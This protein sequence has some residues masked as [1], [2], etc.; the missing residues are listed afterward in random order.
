MRLYTHPA[1]LR[2][3]GG[4]GHP[5]SPA[6]LSA[7]LQAIEQA[8]FSGIEW[9]EAPLASRE[10]LARAHGSALIHRVLDVEVGPG[11]RRIDADTAMN[12]DSAEAALRAAGA[13]CAAIDAVLGGEIRRAFCAVRPPGHHATRDE[14]MGFC[15]FNS[16][17]VGAMHALATHA[18]QRVAIVDFDV[19]HGNGSQDI[20]WNE[21]RIMYLSSHQ[22]ALYP[23][24][25]LFDEHG[26]SGNIVNAP[27]PE[28]SDGS[29]LRRAYNDHLL[30]ALEH[31]APQLLL[32]SAGFDAH[33]LDPLAGLNL[34]ADDYR[35][36]TRELVAV[37]DRHA[38]GRI[39]STLEGGYSLT[40]LRESSVAHVGAM[41]G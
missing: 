39:V 23:G 15:L 7:V 11:G 33:R 2:H 24:T 20:I 17:A 4:P 6:R 8:Q 40:A 13:V 16:V 12:A 1:C 10:Q 3:S 27:L 32:I 34:V 19:H 30:P 5:E 9:V 35:W 28:G 21:P 18:L 29:A 36:L 38:D 14:P 26:G 41:L 31:F 25:G 22:Q 37:A